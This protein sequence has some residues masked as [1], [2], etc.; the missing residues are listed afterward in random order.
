MM[1]SQ[2]RTTQ[3]VESGLASL[4]LVSLTMRLSLI[5]TSFDHTL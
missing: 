3:V 4:T 2:N 1:T 5:E